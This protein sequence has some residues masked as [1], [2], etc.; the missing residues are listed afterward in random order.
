MDS[1][2]KIDFQSRGNHFVPIIK[3]VQP[4]RMSG[5]PS[6]EVFEDPKDKLISN[7]LHTPCLLKRNSVFERHSTE[8][9]PTENPHFIITTIASIEED[10]LFRRFKSHIMDR[11]ISWEDFN[12]IHSFLH[13]D[14][15][16]GYVGA[17]K[18]PNNL[19]KY[20]K[21][22]DFFQWLSQQ[23]HWDNHDIKT[24]AYSPKIK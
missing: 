3:I 10:N 12:E 16:G 7:L 8:S 4:I 9:H 11:I 13:D 20:Q 14:Y 19:D 6:D 23:E 22:E 15:D 1:T 17:R 5:T 18:S 2:L 24:N 21:I